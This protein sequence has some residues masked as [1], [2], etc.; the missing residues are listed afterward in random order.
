MSYIDKFDV[1]CLTETFADSTFD[2]SR[3]F[4]GYVKF[5]AQ[6]KKLST[7]G[8]NS[9]GVLLLIRQ[10]L[11]AFV[12]KL[13]V[14]CENTVVV[15]IDR[16]VFNLDKDVLLIACYVAPENS[17]LYDTLE[18]NDGIQILEESILQAVQNEDLYYLLCGD[19]NART[20]CEQSKLA[21]VFTYTPGC[22]DNDDGDCTCRCSK[23]SIVNNFGKSLLNLCFML[24]CVIV[25]GFC[26][27]DVDGQFT[28][29]SPHG[30]SVIDYFIV[31]EPLFPSHC[32][33]CVG[34]RVDSWHLP[35]EFEWKQVG[36][37]A[38]KPAQVESY[39]DCIVWSE[40]CS[41]T[42]KQ[43]L[44]SDDFKRCM[45]DAH[46]ALGSDIDHSVEIFLNALYCAAACVI[47]TIGKKKNVNDWFDEECKQKKRTVKRVLKRFQRSKKENIEIRE[48]YIKERKEYKQL[49]TR[50]KNEFDQR[51]IE[52]LKQ[53]INNPKII[54]AYYQVS[55]LKGYNIQ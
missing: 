6:A 23:D 46:L 36:R 49:L 30:S 53:S 40:N 2:F 16:C 39:E 15:K 28:Y 38:D 18:L 9:G 55:E 32:E 7:Q 45:Q 41:F 37:I 42:Y 13:E 21:E 10:S 43:E 3:L 19:L 11:S 50:K 31:S 29:V 52:K 5:A 22:D 51:R 8:R 26:D 27:S 44:D 54:L 14:D 34:D 17:P 47:R 12:K 24:D 20:G 33:L 1:A 4:A 35:V 48:M 25:N